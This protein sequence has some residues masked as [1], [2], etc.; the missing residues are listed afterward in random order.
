MSFRL[1]RCKALGFGQCNIK[2]S[3]ELK[4]LVSTRS[5]KTGKNNAGTRGQPIEKADARHKRDLFGV[6]P[7]R[8]PSRHS[9][10]SVV[11]VTGITRLR[12]SQRWCHKI[13]N[14]PLVD[15]MLLAAVQASCQSKLSTAVWTDRPCLKSVEGL[16]AVSALPVLP[17]RGN[18][19]TTRT[20]K[21]FPPRQLC[22]F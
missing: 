20:G 12:Q 4:W 10:Y 17:E 11:G 18:R 2:K 9:T 3:G 1:L 14:G 19:L 5:L 22:E 21:P 13:W 6:I 7:S 15:W 8:S 16:G